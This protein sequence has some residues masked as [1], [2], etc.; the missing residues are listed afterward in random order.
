MTTIEALKNSAEST[1]EWRGHN[2]GKWWD[3]DNGQSSNA[4]CSNL[5]CSAGVTVHIRPAPNQIDIGGNAVALN[6]PVA[7]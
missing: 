5:Q 3:Y 6:C 7:E 1:C 2:L 4:D